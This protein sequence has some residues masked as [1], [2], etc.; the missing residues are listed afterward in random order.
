MEGV[1]VTGGGFRIAGRVF[2]HERADEVLEC[3]RVSEEESKERWDN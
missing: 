1:R 3:R 2:K